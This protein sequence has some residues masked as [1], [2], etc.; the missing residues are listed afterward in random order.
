[1]RTAIK[2]QMPKL[3]IRGT[4]TR[5]SID[6]GPLRERQD[7]SSNPPTQARDED[8]ER[9]RWIKAN[10]LE[11]LPARKDDEQRS[12][13]MIEQAVMYQFSLPCRPFGA[14]RRS[15]TT[16]PGPAAR[17]GSVVIYGKD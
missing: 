1:M 11:D 7:C 13:D 6:R 12:N 16:G 17:Y 10:A 3:N 8:E 15:K 9:E 5:R 2:C 14:S 4:S